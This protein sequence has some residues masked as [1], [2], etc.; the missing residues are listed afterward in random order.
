MDLDRDILKYLKGLLATL[1][2]QPK[3]YHGDS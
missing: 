1:L 3:S 2:A